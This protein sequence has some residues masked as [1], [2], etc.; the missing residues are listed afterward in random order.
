VLNNSF[1][2]HSVLPGSRRF[3]SASLRGIA[4]HSAC[5]KNY[6]NDDE[7]ASLIKVEVEGGIF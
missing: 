4:I 7:L 6:R 3:I 1:K 5:I 2:A